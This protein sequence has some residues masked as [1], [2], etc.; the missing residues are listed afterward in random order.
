MN[1]RDKMKKFDQIIVISLDTL[2]ADCIGAS[3]KA[4]NFL[5]KYKIQ[6]TILMTQMLDDVLN[7]SAYYNNCF[8]S[9]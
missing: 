4:Y 8:T 6:S 9:A 3:P 5:K 1:Q 7:K 2:R